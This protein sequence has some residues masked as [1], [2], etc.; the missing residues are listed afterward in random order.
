MDS[1]E[2][3]RLTGAQGATGPDYG[4]SSLSQ[5][6]Y[7]INLNDIP[8]V[9]V[10]ELDLNSISLTSTM[11]W[12]NGG[13]STGAMGG[14]ATWTTTG[15]GPG[16]GG[17]TWGGINA[18][19]AA[20]HANGEL[21]L[22]GQNADIKINDRSLTDW[23]TQIEQRLNLLTPNPKLEQEWDELRRLGERYRKLEKQC[24]EKAEMWNKL[25]SMPPVSV[26]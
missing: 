22:E 23:M 13:L 7:Q 18:Q 6:D 11:N 17:Y 24:Q 20:I 16:T 9:S 5:N 14:T 3:D 2:K 15:T 21:R 4:H 10:S 12:P 26:K 8:T 1:D 19:P 25:K